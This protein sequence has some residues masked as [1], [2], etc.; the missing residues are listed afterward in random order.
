MGVLNE[1]FKS[2]F[3]L[4]KNI[5]IRSILVLVIPGVTKYSGFV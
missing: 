4:S 2:I 3:S 1:V 5:I